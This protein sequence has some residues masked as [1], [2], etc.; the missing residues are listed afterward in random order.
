MPR[1]ERRDAM[2]A[3]ELLGFVA[4]YL[5]ALSRRS[6]SRYCLATAELVAQG[7]AVCARL[8]E[9]PDAVAG[10][11]GPAARVHGMADRF[12]PTLLNFG[13]EAYARWGGGRWHD[14]FGRA[15]LRDVRERLPRAQGGLSL[16]YIQERV[17]LPIPR[18]KARATAR[19][20][21]GRNGT[22][23]SSADPTK[24]RPRHAHRRF[25]ARQ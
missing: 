1:A 6:D 23:W 7:A 3:G 2:L 14:A 13:R 17:G 21:A 4:F 19:K 24:P 10:A 20:S 22:A 5:G 16:R 8:G 18:A 25:R 11:E 12:G 9:P 15:A